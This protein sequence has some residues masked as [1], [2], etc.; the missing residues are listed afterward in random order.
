M[1]K[2]VAAEAAEKKL[3][4][5]IRAGRVRRYHGIDWIG[6][7]IEQGIVTDSEGE[8][9]RELEALTA[10]VIAVD[11]FDPPRCKP[12][13]MTPGAQRARRRERG[14]RVDGA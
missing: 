5:A 10:R 8:Q 1:E 2:A 13:Y 3:D 7:A 11:H 14:G 9:L 4:R 6:E 12:H